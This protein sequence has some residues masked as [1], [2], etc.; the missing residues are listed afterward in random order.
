MLMWYNGFQ[1]TEEKG[2][3]MRIQ[4]ERDGKVIFGVGKPVKELTP[5]EMKA[6][7]A[8][9]IKESRRIHDEFMSGVPSSAEGLKKYWNGLRFFRLPF[10]VW[11]SVWI[12]LRGGR[13]WYS[14]EGRR[15]IMGFPVFMDE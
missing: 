11:E 14:K 15:I 9:A 8:K 3:E 13:V 10:A 7:R 12:F 1:S 6:W 4:L 2:M 5:E